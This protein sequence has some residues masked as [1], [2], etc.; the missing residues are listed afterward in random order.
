MR[1]AGKSAR[2]MADRRRRNA[3]FVGLIVLVIALILSFFLLN[4]NS[5]GIGGTAVLIILLAIRFLSDWLEAYDRRIRKAERRA[6]RGAK[7]EEAAGALLEALGPDYF[8]LHDV[9]SPYGN[10]DHIVIGR[11]NGV[12]LIE[13]KSHH[14]KVDLAEGGILVN[15]KPPEKDFIKQVLSNTFWLNEKTAEIT[16]VHPW[17]T[18]ILVFT[19]A[20]V[21]YGRSIKNV[22]IINQRYLEGAIKQKPY[23]GELHARIWEMRAAVAQGLTQRNG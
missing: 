10:I 13:T 21:P 11:T 9:A 1:R 18:P 12:F 15:G 7:A 4:A 19:N 16:A 22:R 2:E 14:G 20:F 23:E 6:I 5:L 17:I 8:V 3:I